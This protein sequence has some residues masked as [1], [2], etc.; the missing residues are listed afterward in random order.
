MVDRA[1]EVPDVDGRQFELAGL[2][3]VGESQGVVGSRGD[4][5][6]VS[7]SRLTRRNVDLVIHDHD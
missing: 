1:G 4:V 7:K 6:G 3:L 5:Q 2:A